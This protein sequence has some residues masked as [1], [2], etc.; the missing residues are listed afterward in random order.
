[1]KKKGLAY[2]RMLASFVV[3][4]ILPVFVIVAFYYFSSR[5]IEK[6]VT[7]SSDNLLQTIQ[8]VCDGQISVYRNELLTY[9]FDEQV[10][11]MGTLNDIDGTEY[12][13]YHDLSNKVLGSFVK[14]A[15][16]GNEVKDIFLYFP[17]TE[18]VIS[19]KEGVL[20]YE[21][22]MQ[23]H[24]ADESSYIQLKQYLQTTKN[25]GEYVKG[26]TLWG[27][28]TL[29]LT[30]KC[31]KNDFDCSAVICMWVDM[32]AISEK[33]ASVDW[34]HGYEWAILDNNNEIIKSA[35][36]VSDDVILQ[37]V[38]GST[39]VEGPIM[40]SVYSEETEWRYVL[41]LP[42]S[43]IEDAANPIRIFFVITM[44]I[45]VLLGVISTMRFTRVNYT[46]I[47]DTLQ[48]ITKKVGKKES[49]HGANEYQ[50]I[51]EHVDELTT[52]KQALERSFTAKEKHRLLSG[53]LMRSD[54]TPPKKI[55]G[56]LAPF[57]AGPN[58][59][60]LIQEKTSVAPA[61]VTE[62]DRKLK[63]F[64]VDNVLTEL[65]SEYF[66]CQ[67]VNM[68][69]SQAMM[70]HADSFEDK[71]ECLQEAIQTFQAFLQEKFNFYVTVTVGGTHDGLKGIH[72]SYLETL[73]AEEFLAAL[74]QDYIDF[75]DIRD[76][77]L[78][79]Y[80]Y[81]MQSEELVYKAIQNDNPELAIA[82]INK[83][84]EETFSDKVGGGSQMRRVMITDIYCTLVKVADE[85]GCIEKVSINIADM[86]GRQS[87]GELKVYFAEI[88]QN[89]CTEVKSKTES[90]AN[91]DLCKKVLQ[92]IK[93]NYSDPDLNVS[94]AALEF[95]VSPSTLSS[96]Y[97]KETGNSL[98]QVINEI[99][100]EKAAMFL[101][102]GCSV[103]D[104]GQK[105]GIIDS[106]SFIRLFKRYMGMTPGQYKAN[107]SNEK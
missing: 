6:Q 41:Y 56:V 101:R 54:V 85:K 81:S 87:I 27:A 89:I 48:Y 34:R 21:V 16:T 79:K 26:S 55:K 97:K 91:A 46:P 4:F 5:I 103:A 63:Q 50:L 92:Y 69:N 86:D 98:L 68:D 42:E 28:N 9:T 53:M 37:Y 11:E 30:N 66:T 24:C 83:I 84:L 90:T 25:A 23:Q 51:R 52:S 40:N 15:Q 18:R 58:K 96:V 106:S 82:F 60:A 14:F 75:E 38:T 102:E 67:I 72:S 33:V 20:R 12:P 22:Y 70:I 43:I 36:N 95:H 49:A 65:L 100:I 105:I 61:E 77:A 47:E 104:A 8:S 2:R 7:K 17:K 32:R 64:I 10:R 88:V 93:E 94:K 62:Q 3:A 57:T 80:T 1:M 31:W 73:E 78:R 29:L 19:R 44:V 74:E 35:E 59:V 45:C 39:K 99:K 71:H 13:F 76:N 107:F